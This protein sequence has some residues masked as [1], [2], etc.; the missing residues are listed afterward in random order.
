MP[1]NGYE[2]ETVANDFVRYYIYKYY[3]SI[4]PHSHN[5]GLSQNEKEAFYGKTSNWLAIKI[6]HYTPTFPSTLTA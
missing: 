2:N 4:R 1:K 3:N 5:L 6:D